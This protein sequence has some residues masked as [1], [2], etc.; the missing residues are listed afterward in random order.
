MTNERCETCQ[1]TL[2]R[3]VTYLECYMYVLYSL[4]SS[5]QN[6]KQ[7]SALHH[8]TVSVI[9]STCDISTTLCY[10]ESHYNISTTKHHQPLHSLLDILMMV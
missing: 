1:K 10:T 8:T 7:L 4:C 9:I 5:C 6:D 3:T 2:V